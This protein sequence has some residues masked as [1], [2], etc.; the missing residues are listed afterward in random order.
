MKIHEPNETMFTSLFVA[1]DPASS[2]PV[3][4]RSYLGLKCHGGFVAEVDGDP[5]EEAERLAERL[6]EKVR[7]AALEA[8]LGAIGQEQ[9]AV[10]EE[11]R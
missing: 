5:S 4:Q 9:R 2:D 7:V 1:G 10:E 3:A 11:D 6:A 8:L